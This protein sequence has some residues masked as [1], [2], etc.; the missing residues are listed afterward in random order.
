VEK[1]ERAR[2]YVGDTLE[3]DVLEGVCIRRGGVLEGDM[4]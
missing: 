3:V 2:N 4:Y 1:R